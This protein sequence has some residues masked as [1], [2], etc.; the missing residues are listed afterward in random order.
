M[1]NILIVED[2]PSLRELLL[3]QMEDL[4]H[5]ARAAATLEEGRRRLREAITDAVLLDY[6]LPDGTGMDLLKDIKAQDPALPVVMIT[7]MGDTTLAIEA[8]K[9]GA[10]DFIRKPMDEVELATTLTNV[11]NAHRLSRKVAAVTS[12]DE[13]QVSVGHIIGQSRSILDICKTIGKVA[14]TDTSVLITGESG[15]GKEVVAR[16]IHYHSGRPGLFLPI[17]CSAIVE[18]LLESELFGHEKGSFTGAVARKEGK[19]EVANDGT[20]FLDE[21]G[22]LALPLQAKLLR[23]LQER[24]FERVGGTQILETSARIIAATNRD[25]AARVAEKA[26]REDLFFRLGVVTLHLPP[27]RERMEDLPLLVEHL[28]QKI[29]HKVHK[30][31]TRVSQTAWQAMKDY[32]WPGNV[33]E[34]ENVLTRAVV[35]A[36]TDTITPDLLGLS[37]IPAKPA[38]VP[39]GTSE[40][41]L[42][43]LDALE[44]RQVRSILK[45]THWHKGKACEILG[46]SRPA[47]ERKIKKYGLD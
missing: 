34:L 10:Y 38:S 15:T 12:A 1:A 35:L 44:Q 21:I 33:R 24:T 8:M 42:I 11:L 45:H 36:R 23:V 26:F 3:M 13:Y 32:P 40:P 46:I 29:N 14:T 5:G 30:A 37:A 2:D 39:T 25:L 16:A 43:T 41:E 47:L 7:G 4:G 9:Q 28:M 19:F 20:L 27:L 18:T 22:E 6:Q 17:N 31:I